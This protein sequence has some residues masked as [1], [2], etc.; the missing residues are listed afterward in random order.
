[1]N[2]PV[3]VIVHYSEVPRMPHLIEVAFQTHD[4][5]KIPLS[6]WVNLDLKVGLPL[7]PNQLQSLET[8]SAVAKAKDDAYRYLNWKPRTANEVVK[9]LEKKQYGPAVTTR[10]VSE[11]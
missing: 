4:S 7:L 5:L 8:E 6:T 3:D 11:L 2:E 10:V 9:Y 1:M